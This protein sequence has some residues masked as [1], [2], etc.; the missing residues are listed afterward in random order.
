MCGEIPIRAID[1]MP[2]SQDRNLPL[3]WSVDCLVIKV[4]DRDRIILVTP[5]SA[6]DVRLRATLVGR[7]LHGQARGFSQLIF[8]NINIR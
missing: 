3:M 7:D 4:F 8:W 5:K 6:N 1:C 2:L